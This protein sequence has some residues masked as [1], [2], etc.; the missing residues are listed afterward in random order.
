MGKGKIVI[1]LP[2]ATGI[3]PG[4][5]AIDLGALMV[6]L[7]A[8]GYTVIPVG[9]PR[10]FV[11][12]ARNAIG[13]EAIKFDCDYLFFLDDDTYIE[14]S[15]V[16]KLIDLDKDISSPPVADRRGGVFLNVFDD[17]LGKKTAIDKTQKVKAIGCATMLIKRK[18]LDT[19]FGEYDTPFEF[20]IGTSEA[21]KTPISEDVGF[22]LR[23]DKFGYETWAVKGIRTGH[24][25]DPK[26]YIYEG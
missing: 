11:S 25:G 23:A 14:P 16:L 13:K 24:L 9:V 17:H 22:C 1:G 10:S 2:N 20:Q 6:K 7:V 21:G 5:W 8:S 12:D 15:G 19:L 3:V 18:V 26:K 4:D